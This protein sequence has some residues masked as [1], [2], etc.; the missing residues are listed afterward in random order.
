MSTTL[1]PGAAALLA[2]ALAL[3][4][5]APSSPDDEVRTFRE[6]GKVE[7]ERDFQKAHEVEFGKGIEA[8]C[9]IYISDFFDKEFLLP[10]TEAHSSAAR[11]KKPNC[12]RY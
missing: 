7:L 12:R 8:K 10:M 1:L 4:L 11:T 9:S 5:G 2:A 6:S 3:P